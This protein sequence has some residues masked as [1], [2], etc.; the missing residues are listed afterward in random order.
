MKTASKEKKNDAKNWTLF[1]CCFI[2]IDCKINGTKRKINDNKIKKNKKKT[3][4]LHAV[5]VYVNMSALNCWLFVMS[6]EQYID[7]LLLLS[8]IDI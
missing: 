5:T 8:S 4:P 7:P 6:T 1:N 2:F 3:L